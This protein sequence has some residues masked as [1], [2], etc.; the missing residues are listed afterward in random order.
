MNERIPEV[1]V[2]PDFNAPTP[3]AGELPPDLLDIHPTIGFL[4][5]AALFE[6]PLP[7][8]YDGRGH[9]VGY[10]VTE[11]SL[12][13][14]YLALYAAGAKVTLTESQY[15][16]LERASNSEMDSLKAKDSELADYIKW[17]RRHAM[18]RAFMTDRIHRQ[19]ETRVEGLAEVDFT[20][21]R[22]Y[23]P[24]GI[25][26]PSDFDATAPKQTRLVTYAALFAHSTPRLTNQRSQ[27]VVYL[28]LYAAGA[29]IALNKQQFR[30][31]ERRVKGYIEQVSS[32]HFAGLA[33]GK[34]AHYV[35]NHARR[36]ARKAG[37]I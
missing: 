19:G 20:V 8:I 36:R 6:N 35:L 17:V 4:T 24:L 30:L 10:R 11:E 12:S 37:L 34:H 16:D 33:A 13:V 2:T 14:S 29:R 5:V 7:K 21:G 28:A 18:Q 23:G 22:G 15:R 32:G 1:T 26:L 25:G 31:L 9:T 27:A 3:Y